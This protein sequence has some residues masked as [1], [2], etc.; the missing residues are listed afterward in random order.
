[1]K[2]TKSV[3]DTRPPSNQIKE[4]NLSRFTIKI[5]LSEWPNVAK[6]VFLLVQSHCQ[7]QWV[8]A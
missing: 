3:I 4:I 5:I 1:M 7:Y 6:T 2:G 8:S